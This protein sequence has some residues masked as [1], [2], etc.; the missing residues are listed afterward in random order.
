[1]E[2]TGNSIREF[3]LWGGEALLRPDLIKFAVDYGKKIN[4]ECWKIGTNAILLNE[5]VDLVNGF[6]LYVS[7]DGVGKYNYRSTPTHVLK[8]KAWLKCDKSYVVCSPVCD[9]TKN[10]G[11]V[12][13]Q[14]KSLVDLGFFNFHIP[15]VL[16]NDRMPRAE[17]IKIFEREYDK[18]VKMHD[19]GEINIGAFLG[20]NGIAQYESPAVWGKDRL[21]CWVDIDGNMYPTYFDMLNKKNRFGD[22]NSGIDNKTL[23]DLASKFGG[24]SEN[25]K[26]GKC[27]SQDICLISGVF[28]Y[29]NIEKE[30]PIYFCEGI[31]A[32]YKAKAR[33]YDRSL[34]EKNRC[35][36]SKTMI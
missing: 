4:V 18:L 36:N 35:L 15:M 23:S 8:N 26:C 3:C 22:C 32:E 13:D 16:S 27:K 29:S 14:I 21:Y 20:Y 34:M 17:D 11:N 12:T 30:K 10:D 31:C 33:C 6:D 5:N 28:N 24:Y 2:K 9:V 19:N 7:I 1:M 25:K